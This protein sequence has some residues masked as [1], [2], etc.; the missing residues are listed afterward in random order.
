MIT[1]AY[2]RKKPCFT[3]RKS[4]YEDVRPSFIPEGSLALNK[5]ENFFFSKI[6]DF[7][8]KM[9]HSLREKNDRLEKHELVPEQLVPPSLPFF[10]KR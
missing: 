3:L 4:F 2:G 7:L 1:S 8:F 6:S 5:G 10:Q 9:H